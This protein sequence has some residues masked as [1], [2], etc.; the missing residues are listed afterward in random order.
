MSSI[1]AMSAISASALTLPNNN[2]NNNSN[3]SNEFDESSIDCQ[4]ESKKIINNLKLMNTKVNGHQE[5]DGYECVPCDE[6]LN[7]CNNGYNGCNDLQN[8]ENSV[9]KTYVTDSHNKRSLS[10]DT[11]S[12]SA[13][14]DSTNGRDFRDGNGFEDSYSE[15][16]TLSS[17]PVTSPIDESIG[18]IDEALLE[19]RFS[20]LGFSDLRRHDSPLIQINGNDSFDEEDDGIICRAPLYRSTSLKTGKTPPALPTARN[21]FALQTL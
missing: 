17:S 14:S 1:V 21:S 16:S 5:C 4:N 19:E 9:S 10:I 2:N 8:N 7:K 20:K 12:S 11:K 6:V 15:A 3:K 18:A 13:S